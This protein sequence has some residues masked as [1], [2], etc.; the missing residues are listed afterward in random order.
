MTY[1]ASIA[2]TNGIYA[3]LKSERIRASNPH[4]AALKALHRAEMKLLPVD[5]IHIIDREKG[6]VGV[7][8]HG[9]FHEI[10]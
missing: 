9:V 6:V 4:E 5:E 2:Y 3:Q 8:E 1:L 7:V 10:L